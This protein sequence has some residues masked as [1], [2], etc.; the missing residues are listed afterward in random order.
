MVDPHRNIYV[1]YVGLSLLTTK[2]IEKQCRSLRRHPVLGPFLQAR[3]EGSMLERLRR[4]R[5]DLWS[6][7]YKRYNQE[8]GLSEMLLLEC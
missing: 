1:M 7:F 6:Q 5:E 4:D 8:N 3:T 2:V